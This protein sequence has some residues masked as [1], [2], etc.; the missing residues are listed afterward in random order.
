MTE[1]AVAM[2]RVNEPPVGARAFLALEGRRVLPNCVRL[3]QRGWIE[4]GTWTKR[5]NLL[6]VRPWGDAT[7][8]RVFARAS[9]AS[10]ASRASD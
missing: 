9:L 6:N 10:K 5:T 7:D 2:E 3:P 8:L 4:L 1:D